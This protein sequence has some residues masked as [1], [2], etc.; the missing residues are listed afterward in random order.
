MRSHYTE[1]E[2]AQKCL[3]II[4]NYSKQSK[5][6][7][8]FFAHPQTMLKDDLKRDFGSKTNY[9]QR[10]EPKSTDER[11][12]GWSF[13]S[14][15][16][17][18][19]S[20]MINDFINKY[21]CLDNGH[22]SSN[23]NTITLNPNECVRLKA[24]GSALSKAKSPNKGGG[25]RQ[26]INQSTLLSPED[27]SN[28][29]A[30]A[31]T[32]AQIRSP[33]RSTEIIYESSGLRGKYTMASNDNVGRSGEV[34]DREQYDPIGKKVALYEKEDSKESNMRFPLWSLL[35]TK[36]ADENVDDNSNNRNPA[37]SRN[38][39]LAFNEYA[40]P[41]VESAT[42][43]PQNA[44]LNDTRHISF[45]SQPQSFEITN[46]SMDSVLNDDDADD[47]DKKCETVIRR[48]VN[49]LE[50]DRI[51]KA[52]LKRR[53]GVS[54]MVNRVKITHD[55]INNVHLEPTSGV[56]AALIHSAVSGLPH[57]IPLT[58]DYELMNA[59]DKF[60]QAD[61]A[62]KFE[63]ALR[64]AEI[65]AKLAPPGYE[66]EAAA[67]AVRQFQYQCDEKEDLNSMPLDGK[68]KPIEI[69]AYVGST[70]HKNIG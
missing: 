26:S 57:D 27:P 15:D 46:N 25:R 47:T 32:N 44:D 50:F 20:E 5:K 40:E 14:I 10:Q 9:V 6:Y 29:T 42:G 18:N 70:K 7:D 17:I 8:T 69:V 53:R 52:E 28:A 62:C 49:I 60:I 23:S 37:D 21:I 65:A 59:I 68:K 19:S 4:L 41:K 43:P 58:E 30:V 2:N 56:K 13:Q 55:A 66:E 34:L 35:K 54:S 38:E 64:A 31:D 24:G 1:Q 67:S 22:V 3:D 51:F 36:I 11:N 16:T 45:A 39:S 33:D 61:N 12:K 63:E 48:K